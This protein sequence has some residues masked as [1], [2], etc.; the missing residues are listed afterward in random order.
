VLF[1]ISTAKETGSIIKRRKRIIERAGLILSLAHLRILSQKGICV[2][3]LT[4][5]VVSPRSYLV[6][7]NG[8]AVIVYKRPVQQQFPLKRI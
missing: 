8:P 5:T 4:V 6:L 7:L 2:S 1:R 3:V